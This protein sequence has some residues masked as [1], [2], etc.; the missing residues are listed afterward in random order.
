[1][2]DYQL[3]N[4]QI[5][6]DAILLQQQE[7]TR[8][9]AE[10]LYLVVIEDKITNN[11]ASK[12]ALI[13]LK[14][15][16]VNSNIQDFQP[17]YFD[18]EMNYLCSDITDE[19]KFIL[20][21]RFKVL[22]TDIR[23]NYLI[24]TCIINDG[25][26]I[27]RTFMCKTNETTSETESSKKIIELSELQ[28]YDLLDNNIFFAIDINNLIYFIK[29]NMLITDNVITTID[30]ANELYID[31][32]NI[33]LCESKYS[34]DS[35]FQTAYNGQ[36]YTVQKYNNLYKLIYYNINSNNYYRDPKGYENK[37]DIKFV[38]L[39]SDKTSESDEKS[40]LEKT[41]ICVE[42]ANSK[43]AYDYNLNKYFL[44][45]NPS[46]QNSVELMIK[47]T[48]DNGIN[49]NDAETITA[50]QLAPDKRPNDMDKDY[51]LKMPFEYF[52]YDTSNKIIALNII[53]KENG[54][55]VNGF[56]CDITNGKYKYLYFRN[57]ENSNTS[58]NGK[59]I[60][61]YELVKVLPYNTMTHRKVIQP[62]INITYRKPFYDYNEN[63]V[64]K[65]VVDVPDDRSYPVLL[66]IILTKN[67]TKIKT[68]TLTIDTKKFGQEQTYE[69]SGINKEV[70]VYHVTF[71]ATIKKSENNQNGG[72]EV[73]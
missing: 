69:W 22:N 49:Y 15:D 7:V 44:Y 35:L 37:I 39:N 32:Q 27:K 13:K 16:G 8:Y 51:K 42:E 60:L 67:G 14:I 36:I 30:T 53:S 21:D 58:Q 26:N 29:D 28:N 71:C 57:S 43:I 11:L 40:S 1:M 47:R 52:Y 61:P 23:S 73:T 48:N 63:L 6:E 2:L 5:D 12:I 34:L 55:T 24:Y 31:E 56:I 72:S 33:Q 17:I 9:F 19:T 65:Y 25:S 4:N 64:V 68:V 59:G 62:N 54:F 38:K 20:R 50:I 10:D 70:G 66:D 18:N 46:K 3:E 45:V 41:I